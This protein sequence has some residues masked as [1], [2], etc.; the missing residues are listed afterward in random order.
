MGFQPHRSLQ[1]HFV[2]NCN[3]ICHEKEKCILESSLENGRDN[4][5]SKQLRLTCMDGLAKPLFLGRLKTSKLLW[6]H[7]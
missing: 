1:T 5:P 6:C 4:H 2:G 3:F 7:M